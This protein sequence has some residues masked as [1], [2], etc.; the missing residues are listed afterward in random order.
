MPLDLVATLGDLVSLPSVNPMGREVVAPE[1]FEYRVTDYLDKLFSRHQI[2]CARQP[3]AA[4][5]ENILARVDGD[6]PPE[7]GGELLLFDV[8]QDTVGVEGMT[9]EPWTPQIRDHRLYGRG[10]CDVKGALSS[11]L[12][13]LVRLREERAISA[14]AAQ[15]P[16]PTVVVACTVNEEHGFS[17][18]KGVCKLWADCRADP[19]ATGAAEPESVAM[20]L[21]QILPR[22]PDAAIV[23]EPTRLDIVVAHKGM[24]RWACR[25]HGRAA[26]SSDP[27]A[28]D[29]AIY[30]MSPIVQ[31]FER[32]A[33][34]V[35][36]YELEH[37]LC[38]RPTLSVGTIAGGSGVNTVPDRCTIEIDH[39]LLPGADPHAA[40]QD[41]IDYVSSG[42]RDAAPS[43]PEMLEH[44]KHDPPLLHSAGLTD[45]ANGELADRL[46]RAAG[47]IASQTRRIGVPF[48]TNAAIYSAAGVPTVVFGPGSIEQAHT[49]DEWISLEQLSSGSEILYRFMTG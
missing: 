39:R 18:A 2:L 38:G 47:N 23:L 45:S 17:G 16:R 3:I 1:C 48:G 12:A 35:L 8:H 22:R 37:P 14:A 42:L 26:H 15:R 31:L 4:L 19:S 25:T 10:S 28:G 21:K 5:R 33:R 36:A 24:V 49:A 30:R 9:I 13:A 6:V 7:N 29:N 34:D 43:D 27:A 11:L 44:V 46:S 32:Y 20:Q 40:W 41:A